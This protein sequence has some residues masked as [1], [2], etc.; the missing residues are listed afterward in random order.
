MPKYRKIPVT[1]EARRLMWGAESQK[2]LME[3]VRESSNGLCSVSMCPDGLLIN[4]LEGTMLAAF[5]D[6]VIRGV[7]G[8]FY[9]CKP[10]IFEKTYVHLAEEDQNI[11]RLGAGCTVRLIYTHDG[12]DFPQANISINLDVPRNLDERDLFDI[13][14]ASEATVKTLAKYIK[15]GT[16][17]ES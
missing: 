15:D 4:T 7:N 2:E 1:I 13:T 17:R 12:T 10:D 5:G 9:P 6:Y 11:K 8:E 16:W 14:N 3:W